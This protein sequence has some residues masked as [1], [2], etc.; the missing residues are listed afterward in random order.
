MAAN[1][2]KLGV[3]PTSTVLVNYLFS[4]RKKLDPFALIASAKN[5]L[6]TG[7]P[8]VFKNKKATAPVP[9]TL[10]GD[11]SGTNRPA[12]MPTA[13]PVVAAMTT[14]TSTAKPTVVAT[15]D[16]AQLALRYHQLGHTL[17]LMW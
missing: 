7:R 13:V 6:A 4:R 8:T 3:V 15:I 16:G 11:R 2:E 1:R 5:H 10:A 17:L 12:P 14:T 9:G